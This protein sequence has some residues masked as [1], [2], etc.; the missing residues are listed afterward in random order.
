MLDVFFLRRKSFWLVCLG[1]AVPAHAMRLLHVRD[2]VRTRAENILTESTG[3]EMADIWIQV[4][5]DV[6][7]PRAATVAVPDILHRE[8]E[9]AEGAGEFERIVMETRW[10]W[11]HVLITARHG[12]CVRSADPARR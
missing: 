8:Y 2:P 5:F 4:L 3:E 1:S 12:D 7:G 9:R 6:G 11:N 10:R